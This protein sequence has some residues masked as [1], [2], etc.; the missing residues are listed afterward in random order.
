MS[1]LEAIRL[2]YPD[3]SRRTLQHWLE[4]GRFKIN[5]EPLYSEKEILQEGQILEAVDQMIKR[6][7]RRLKILYEDRFLIA[8]D[9]PIGLLSVPLDGGGSKSHALGI[10]R[11]HYETKEIHAVHRIDRETSGVLLFAR[12]AKSRDRLKE[13]FEAHALERIYYAV[14]DG[15]V[16]EEKGLWDSPL[17][18]LENYEVV[19]SI[20]GK[21]AVTHF[22][23]I[24]RSTKYTFL[25]L[26]LETG[27]KHQIR[28]HAKLAGHPIVGDKRYGSRENPIGRMALHAMKIALA[29][30]ITDRPLSIESPIPYTFKKVGA[31]YD[32]L[33]ESAPQS[34]RR[35]VRDRQSPLSPPGV[36]EDLPRRE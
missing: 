5:G 8:I 24:R 13:M 23:V 18:E 30:P 21:E 14:V 20:T 4:G 25:K 10:L 34:R 27:R 17:A 32:A 9:K 33:L 22:E 7:P 26:T 16:K 6:Q 28:V 1:A 3:S 31:N 19:P 11:E 36:P 29:H 35:P 15:R 12:G 2:L